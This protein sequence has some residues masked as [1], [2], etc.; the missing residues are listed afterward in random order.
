M[1]RGFMQPAAGL[2]AALAPERTWAADKSGPQTGRIR[3][4][5]S[6]G[7]LL[8]GGI[9]TWLYNVV[10]HLDRSEFDHHVLVR[11]DEEEPFTQAF[12]EKGFRV[13]PC[14][15]YTRPFRY[16]R[17]FRQ[18]IRE[19]GPYDI[20]HVH[21][22]NPNGL[23]ALLFGRR[24]GI[25]TRIIH[26]HNDLRPLLK[27]RGFVYRTYVQATLACLRRFADHG[28]AASALAAESMFGVDWRGDGRWEVLHCGIDLQ[29]F[30]QAID[31]KFRKDLGIPEKAFVVGHVGRFHQQKN[32]AFLV[33]IAEKLLSLCP[34][35][36][37]V[38]IGDG[39]LRLTIVSE[40]VSK[41]LGAKV[42]LVPD[43]LSVPKFMV[44]AMDCFVFPSLYE[45]LGL[46]A[47]EAQAAGLPCFFSDRVPYEAIVV[48]N[49]VQV[50]RLG[51]AP[52]DWA[53]AIFKSRNRKG[54]D[55]EHLTRLRAS[56][57]NLERSAAS[58]RDVYKSLVRSTGSDDLQNSRE[59]VAREF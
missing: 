15:E 12:R 30:D 34:D 26:S 55:T 19:N 18:V 7:H 20:L 41:G 37:F 53:R 11:T 29:P 45:G 38:L 13:I 58:L 39:E 5:H 27:S 33:R 1:S 28:F 56:P 42:T 49:L 36:H 43:T 21:G 35:A 2:P 17:N 22:S 31:R 48:E 54:R 46:V 50:L 47:V 24:F 25:P 40:F 57:F 23:Q 44:S 3:I 32:H 59:T 6:V 8:R 14:L 52:E 10:Q 51:D 16:V 4:L 9:E